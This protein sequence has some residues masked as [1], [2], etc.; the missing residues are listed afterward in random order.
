MSLLIDLKLYFFFLLVTVK[1]D[2]KYVFPK[3]TARLNNWNSGP[4]N[5]ES[6]IWC[7]FSDLILI[8]SLITLPENEASYYFMCW[9]YLIV[10][11]VEENICLPF[12]GGKLPLRFRGDCKFLDCLV[13]A[14]HVAICLAF[15]KNVRH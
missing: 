6:I 5:C 12:A 7:I 10:I 14:F 1:K 15:V 3:C 9:N 2:I 8:L 11:S 4:S 13:H